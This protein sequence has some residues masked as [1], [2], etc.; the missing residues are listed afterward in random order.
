MI[1]SDKTKIKSIINSEKNYKIELDNIEA[2]IYEAI[3]KGKF[4]I[5]LLGTISENARKTLEDLKYK[6]ETGG[7]Y[8]ESCTVISWD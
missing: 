6:V 8:N 2:K 4:S 7:R 1:S 3:D 5:T